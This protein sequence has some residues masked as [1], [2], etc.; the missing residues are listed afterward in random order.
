MLI[1]ILIILLHHIKKAGYFSELQYFPR[2][3]IIV[4]VKLR[5]KLKRMEI[6][7]IVV[8]MLLMVGRG[9]YQ[10]DTLGNRQQFKSAIIPRIKII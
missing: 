9:I 7:G 8:L 6:K 2:I 3:E 5:K 10:R 4:N 1:K